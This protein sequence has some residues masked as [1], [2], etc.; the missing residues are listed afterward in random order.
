MNR[1]FIV[2]QMEEG[3]KEAGKILICMERESTRG[4]T[5]D[6]MKET[7]LMIKK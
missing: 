6:I 5:A 1:V 3:T 7:I 4:R 2:G